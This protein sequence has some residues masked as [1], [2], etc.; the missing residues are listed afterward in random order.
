M[1]K[2][3][4]AIIGCGG[5]GT[6]HLGH[7]L[8]FTDFVDMVGF[9][10]LIPERAEKFREKAGMGEC[11]TDYREM[12]D[13][14][15][16]E[17]VFIC[18]PPYCHGQIEFDL[19]DRGIHFFVEKPLALD[20]ELAKE[21]LRRAEAKG[22]VTAS[23]FQCR[24]SNLNQYGKAFIDRTKIFYVSCERMGGIPTVDW[25]R[26]KSLSGGQ[27][28]E[29]TI[30]QFDIIR[31]L[32]GEPETVF[33]MNAK[34]LIEDAPENYDTDDVSVT[35]VKFKNG[36]VGTISTGCYA[37][38]SAAYDSKIVFS[39]A[40][41]RGELEI[42]NQFRIYG[43]SA[44]AAEEKKDGFVVKGDG[45]LAAVSGGPIVYTQEG[46]AGVLCDRTFIEAAM[47][48]DTTRV[49]SPYRDALRSLA[50]TMACN[51]SMESGKPVVID[52]LLCGI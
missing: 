7:F 40:G 1:K 38:S 21:I 35:T 19:I 37:N 34:G 14:V 28:V 43:E 27:A 39:G 15:N 17:M 48:G 33:S 23:G 12:L 41:T 52:D 13:K 22:L 45:A 25:W 51:I 44:E 46:D 50:F 11:F 3:R 47:A 26:V 42:L 24:Y 29:Q 16:P 9:C 20:M 2:A 32:F 10:D 18:I 6:Y 31:Y 49:R 4:L 5:I 8:Q 30:H 36:V